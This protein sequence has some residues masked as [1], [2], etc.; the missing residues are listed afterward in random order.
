MGIFAAALASL[1]IPDDQI[2]KYE[3]EVK[4]GKFLVLA[5]G[6]A[7]EIERAHSI[8]GTAGASQLT[9]QAVG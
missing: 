3:T 2:V 4:A 9:A 8:L 6:D 7:A 5:R 1:G